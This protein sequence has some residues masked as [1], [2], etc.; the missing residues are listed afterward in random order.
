MIEQD[1]TP[2]DIV[3]R[4]FKDGEVIGL[5]P[6]VV[7]YSNGNITSYMHRGQ[8]SEANYNWC[9]SVTKLA[10]EVEYN[11]LKKELESIGYLVNVIK[12]QNRQKYLKNYYESRK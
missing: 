2:T 5:M 3:F 11:D 7:D 4:K 6:H 12:K 1:T 9:V 10:S 8:H